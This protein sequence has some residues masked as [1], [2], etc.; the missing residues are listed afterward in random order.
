MKCTRHPLE[1]DVGVCAPC[2][3]ERLLALDAATAPSPDDRQASTQ[4]L[5][6]APLPFPRS[7]SPYVPRSAARRSSFL[8][9]FFGRRGRENRERKPQRSSSW[10]SALLHARRRK[11]TSCMSFADDDA[12]EP[13]RDW[14]MSPERSRGGCD[15]EPPWGPWRPQPSSMTWSTA[16][17][18][19]HHG[20]GLAG[21]AMCFSPL[22]AA[23]SSRRRSRVA[24]F[25]FSG[26]LP[27]TALAPH[28]HRRHASVG[29]PVM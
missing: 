29:G 15:A 18:H 26:E 9:A 4:P 2:L 22:A 5:S 3:R 28:R 24:E 17:H 11:K 20:S 23:S 27:R 7:V 1:D 21:F 14:G 19:H 12:A 6:P 13:G 8:S 10:L 16:E 25:G